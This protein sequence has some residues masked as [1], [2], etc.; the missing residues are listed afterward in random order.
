MKKNSFIGAGLAGLLALA[1]ALPVFAE[2]KEITIS[3]EGKC[4]KCLL[5]ETDK[6]QNAIQV[7]KDGKKTTYY[8]VENDVSKKFH[9]NICEEAKK[10]TATGTVKVVDGK[11]QF[12]ATKIELA[13]K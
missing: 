2:D 10:V 1:L 12:T 8:V 13:K 4:A 9:E 7:E 3:G 5:K 6:C 11:Q